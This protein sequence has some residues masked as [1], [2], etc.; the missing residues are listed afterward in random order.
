MQVQGPSS[1]Q[2]PSQVH[3]A[4]PI[5]GPHTSGS[6]EPSTATGS[7]AVGDRLDISEAGQIASRMAE[8]PDIRAERVQDIRAAIL[9]GSYETQDRLGTAVD[10]L[11]DEIA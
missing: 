1:V 8:I 4:Q 10:R 6:I 5:R 11:L 3:A 9:D 2:G 7:A